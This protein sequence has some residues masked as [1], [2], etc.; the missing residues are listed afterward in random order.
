MNERKIVSFAEAHNR[1]I[2]RF[3]NDGLDFQDLFNKARLLR[4]KD[5]KQER[6]DITILDW[7]GL[8]DF[9]QAEIAEE[10]F[11]QELFSRDILM[12]IWFVSDLL[13]SFVKGD[14]SEVGIERHVCSYTEKGNPEY[15]LMA[16]NSAF[17]YFVFWPETRLRRSVHYQKLGSECGPSLYSQ[18]G[19]VAKKPFGFQMAKAFVPIGEIARR[20]FR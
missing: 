5:F 18:Y 3:E 12:S 20:Q 14:I 15:L 7:K 9:F 11:R 13:T 1:M 19:S 4:F 17:L 6:G 2:R 16:V 8:K 10:V